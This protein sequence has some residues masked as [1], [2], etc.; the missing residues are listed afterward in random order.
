MT[1]LALSDHNDRRLSLRGLGIDKQ[2]QP[3]LVDDPNTPLMRGTILFETRISAEQDPK[4]LFAIKATEPDLR[5]LTFQTIAGGGVSVV[6]VQ[7]GQ[8]TH[9]SLPLR[10]AEDLDTIRVT[11]SWDVIAQS[12]RLTIE[13]P[14]KTMLSTTRVAHPQPLSLTDIRGLMLGNGDQTFAQDM[15]FAALSN[16]IEPIGPMPTMLPDT[17]LAT[18]QGYQPVANLRPGDTVMT[19]AAGIVPVLHRIS[20]CLPTN[21]SWWMAQR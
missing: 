4:V 7:G 3:L 14:G 21:R 10:A 2:D 11:Y 6:Q 17:P 20:L 5:S 12:G 18:P 16:Q 13:Y 8:K 15:C 19:H 1:W 9:A